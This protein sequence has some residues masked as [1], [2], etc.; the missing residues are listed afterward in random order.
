MYPTEDLYDGF[1]ADC[2]GVATDSRDIPPGSMF[3]ALHGASF[4]G[5]A[6]VCDALDKGA[7][8]AVADSDEP[9]KARPDLADRIIRTDDT[10]RTLQA[11]AREH[12]RRL[13]IPII[14]IVG[15]NGKTTT[16][17]LVTRVLAEKFEVSATRGNLNNH[18]GVPLTLLSMTRDTQIGVVEMGASA[19]GE[20][21]LLASIAEPNYG[22]ITNIGR[23]HLEGFGGVEG[24]RRGKGELFDFLEE[25]G[26]TAFV[27]IEDAV[28]AEMAAERPN[29]AV[30][31][32]SRT[33][34]DGIE[35]RLEGEY[36][37]AN[38]AAAAE[39][40][41]YF[42]V[43]GERIAHAIGSYEPT[44]NRSQ[45][46]ESGRNTLI[47]DCY[48]ANPSSMAAA[49]ENMRKNTAA[50]KL[51]ILGDM[52]ELGQWSD[53]EHDTVLQAA[54]EIDGAEIY[55]VGEN[56]RKAAERYAAADGTPECRIETFADADALAAR[57]T[58]DPPTGY[59]VLIKGSHG[60]S[61]EKIIKLL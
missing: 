7:A 22:I 4:D 42:G 53:E 19:C 35:S 32:Y 29:M 54:A 15:S 41:L 10:L 17:E 11:L 30:E 47:A 46:V 58:A 52:L 56:L 60:I 24:I 48:N 55:L 33:I 57:L 28:L 8:Y 45:R 38:I 23:S 49:I 50:R 18:I 2:S 61:L 43:D 1:F 59:T 31:Y 36:N 26:G 14:G 3:F 5:N 13:E 6:F 20:I 27:P 44:N 9:A 34:A 12:R 51:L 37:R 40:G 21:A 25:N 16:K 39:T